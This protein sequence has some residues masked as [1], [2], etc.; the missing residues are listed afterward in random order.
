MEF[1]DSNKALD[2]FNQKYNIKKHA[3]VSDEVKFTSSESN[4]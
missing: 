1:E 3:K 2:Y 4:E